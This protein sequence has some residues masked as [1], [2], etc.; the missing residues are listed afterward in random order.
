MIRSV[1]YILLGLLAYGVFLVA[2]VPAGQAFA[3]FQ[4]Q[5]PQVRAAGLSG[6]AW[7]GEAAVLQIA[8]KNLERVD[9]RIKPWSA[10]FGELEIDV[11]LDDADLSGHATLGLKPDGAVRLSNVDLRLAASEFSDLF[12]TPVGL[13]GQFELQ[14]QRA[15]FM[16]QKIQS[17]EGV[18]RWRRAAVTVPL[19]QPLGEFTA[20]LSTTEGGIKARI[21]DDGGPLQLDGT[22]VL[23]PAGAYS[24][25]GS[26]A[27]RDPQQ[28]MLVQGVRALGRPA[29]DGR[30]ALQYS[31]S[32]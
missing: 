30:V 15:E 3:L 19:V 17:A 12:N 31:G 16:G 8:G 2:T 26:V 27:V 14:L 21:K 7:S 23:T 1:G 24:F 22:A 20:R 10:L 11:A 28:Q 25:N 29:A 6:T 5:L 13:G 32:L 18:V 9:W 4:P